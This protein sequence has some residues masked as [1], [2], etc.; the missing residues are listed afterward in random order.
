GRILSYIP[1]SGNGY[2]FPYKRIA[3]RFEDLLHKVDQTIAGSFRTYEA[4]AP[5]VSLAGKYAAEF[6]FNAFIL[7]KKITDLPGS[8][9]NIA[10]GNV[11]VGAHMAVELG[12]KTLAKF[13]HFIIR[14]VLGIKIRSALTA[15]HG[16]SGKAVF[17]YLL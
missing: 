5:F 13:H 3:P 11:Y 4:A 10:G 9:A 1:R 17:K 12:H 14:S 7:S 16:K 2:F 8:Y 6:S 15:T